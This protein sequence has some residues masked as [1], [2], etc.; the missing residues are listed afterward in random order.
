[1][2]RPEFPYLLFERTKVGLLL[3]TRN[4]LEIQVAPL[5]F[6]SNNLSKNTNKLP[7]YSDA[8]DLWH[9]QN[10]VFLYRVMVGVEGF[11]ERF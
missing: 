10:S 5:V 3:S 6:F 1:M 11:E 9:L 2:F 4:T 7:G 8:W